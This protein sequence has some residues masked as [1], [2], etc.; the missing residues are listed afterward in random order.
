MCVFQR[1]DAYLAHCT[2]SATDRLLLRNAPITDTTTLFP[3]ALLQEIVSRK[4]VA[5]HDTAMSKLASGVF[6]PAA[7]QSQGQGRGRGS[8]KVFRS[9]YTTPGRGGG[10]PGQ[11]QAYNKTPAKRAATATATHEGSGDNKQPRYDKSTASSNR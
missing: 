1:R 4:R 5:T 6:R 3:V 8:G 10:N 7:P 2:F 9:N 11:R